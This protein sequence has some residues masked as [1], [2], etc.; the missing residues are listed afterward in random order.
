MFYFILLA[1]IVAALFLYSLR[2]D[3][4]EHTKYARKDG[5]VLPPQKNETQNSTSTPSAA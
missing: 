4:G 5:Q 3:K 1:I 2:T